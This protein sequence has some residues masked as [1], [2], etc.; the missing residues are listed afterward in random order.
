MWPTAD[1]QVMDSLGLLLLDV[2]W[3]ALPSWQSDK[4]L[5]S[6][7][8]AAAISNTLTEV[9]CCWLKGLYVMLVDMLMVS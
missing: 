9:E 5:E 6:Q 7:G 8:G 2:S 3:A 4:D 1:M